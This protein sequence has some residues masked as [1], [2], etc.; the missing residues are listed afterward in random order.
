MTR[1]FK[2]DFTSRFCP[3]FDVT[4]PIMLSLRVYDYAVITRMNVESH[5]TA[6]AIRML[7]V[8]G[9]APDA[10]RSGPAT[11]LP[12]AVG[13]FVATAT[14]LIVSLAAFQLHFGM[15]ATAF[16]FSSSS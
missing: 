14:V 16:V 10:E 4:D 8:S 5:G 6:S 7:L 13:L 3:A 2:R 12:P 9:K 11:S 1:C 15:P